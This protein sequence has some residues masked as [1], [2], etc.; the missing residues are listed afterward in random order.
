[1]KK[2]SPKAKAFNT[3]KANAGHDRQA[4]RRKI[5]ARLR[6]QAA[7]YVYKPMQFIPQ[8]DPG[9]ADVPVVAEEPLTDTDTVK[10]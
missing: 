5:R 8:T 1:M 9:I 3:K 4:R 2:M 7:N 6:H 10:L